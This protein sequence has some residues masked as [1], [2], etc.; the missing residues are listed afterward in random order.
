[1]LVPVPWPVAVGTI[2]VALL[3]AAGV[4]GS[5]TLRTHSE[6]AGAHEAA[7]LRVPV[8]MKQS[9][10]VRTSLATQ[11][12]AF[13]A[14]QGQTDPQVKYMARGSGY[15][16]FFTASDTV[17]ALHSSSPA[18]TARISRNQPPSEADQK[19]GKKNQT[20]AV[21]MRLLDSNPHP[22]IT[23][24]S[25]LPGRSNYFI[26][27]N[28]SQWHANVPQYAR[29][30]YRDVYPGINMAYYGAQKRLEFDFIVG[31]GA[32]PAPIRLGFSGAQR[33]AS[34]KAGNLILSSSAGEVLLHKPIAYQQQDGS[35]HSIDARFVLQAGNQV[36]FE[37]ANYDHTRELVIDPSV[38]YATYLGGTAE[39]DAYGIAI[40]GSGDAYVTGK[41]ASTDFPVTTSSHV[42]GFDVF[43]S[44]ISPDGS[45]L[46]YS[47]Y[48]GGSGDDSG[49]A[50]TVDTLGNAFVTGGTASTDFPATAGAYQKTIKSGSGGFDSFVFELAASSG[51]LTYCTYLGGATGDDIANGIALATDNSG[52]AIVVGHTTSTDFPT[53]PIGG[54][55][56]TVGGGF[57]TKL[58]S[59]GSA[60]V[61]STYL[62][63]GTQ[64]FASAI[65]LDSSDNAYVTGA[66]QSP[67][68]FITTN[69]FQKTCGTA[70]NCNGGLTD[71]FVSVIKADGSGFIYS[72]FL[73]GGSS[74]QGLGIAIDS[75][76]DA[77]V[78]GL[79][80]SSDF[81]P[82]NPIRSSLGGLQ[83]AFVTELNPAGS[84][85]VYS[86]YL[87][88]SNSD[89]GA[90]IAIDANKN[91]YVVGQ[92]ASTDFPVSSNATQSKLGGGNDAFVAEINS[93]GS[94][95]MFATYL[96]GA[97]NE[98]SRSSGSNFSP[99]G[100][101]AVDTAGANLYIAGN[102]SSSDFPA[103]QGVK[104]PTFGG[105]SFDAFVAKYSLSSTTGG[106]F[107]VTNGPL[108]AT[109][110]SPGVSATATITVTS[111]S[112]FNGT[113]NLACSVSPVVSKGPTCS[114]S[115]GSSVNLSANGTATAT[116][117]VATT[118]ASAMLEHPVLPSGLY[119]AMLLPV[120][121]ITL[122]G[123]GLG[124]SARY[125]RK[126]LGFLILGLVLAGLLL[127]LPACSSSSSK[128][129][130]NPGTPAGTYS[131]TVT[132]TS[133][134]ATVTGTPALTLTVN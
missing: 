23:A 87:G 120:G 37:L 72:T 85:L 77:Y 70:A 47:T 131:I 88:G 67:T 13:E 28:P 99:V 134:S 114:F 97:L 52:D 55:P 118:A 18:A 3:V 32:S 60:L 45:S 92:T 110:G 116:L 41:T 90:G 11:P 33:I 56:G 102:T 115:P 36:T 27:N 96:G 89:G 9:A 29:I 63:G 61:Y 54:I 58:N 109:S 62:G 53:N 30:S 78:T 119:Y 130:G 73:G 7:A 46:L 123:A 126:L 1:M 95:I 125:R 10:L 65:A 48:V 44:K 64:D 66:T 24:D 16:A 113:V 71:A 22:R 107:T 106:T 121:G 31:P 4:L 38:S 57:V 132:G 124:S 39:D 21:R 40:N 112:G 26:G 81:P 101:I 74:D 122:L 14:N 50:I 6:G 68:F 129:T 34:D 104:Q 94:Q 117:N 91:V 69:A 43:V 49:N 127:L 51:S 133:G 25:Q 105:G 80:Q 108:S 84:A 83:D 103:T 100:A 35:R 19:S 42:G 20:A 2:A 75:A 8:T 111:V 76:G 82:K 79:T 128:T 12:L 15:T 59:T 93:A 98:N 86:T 17:F 5:A